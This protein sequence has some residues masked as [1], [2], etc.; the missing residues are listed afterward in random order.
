[1]FLAYAVTL[2]P[3]DNNTLLVTSRDF[4]EL[5]TWGKNREDALRRAGDAITGL[6]E[7]YMARGKA[8]PRPHGKMTSRNLVP[9]PTLLAAKLALYGAMREDRMTQAMLAQRLKTT[10]RQVRRLLDPAVSSRFDDLDAA[11]KALQRRTVLSVAK[12]AA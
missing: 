3:D 6:I 11:L 9:L 7:G 1:M 2:R 12:A 10:D 5:T 4:P 8:I